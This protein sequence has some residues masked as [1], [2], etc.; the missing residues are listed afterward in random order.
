MTVHKFTRSPLWVTVVAALVAALVLV[1]VF[2]QGGR[3]AL[4]A[5]VPGTPDPP[6]VVG[7]TA[8]PNGKYPFIVAL[9]NTQFGSTPFQQ[10]FCGGTLI[11]Q[12]SVLTAAHCVF[13]ASAEPL[14]VTVGRTVLDNSN[15][16]KVRAVSSISI[17]PL[18]IPS[19]DDAFDA[20]V[21][22]L[23]NPV[24]GIAPIKLA[25]ANHDSLETPGR[26]VRVA[27]WGNTCQQPPPSGGCTSNFPNRMREA[28]VPI[29]SDTTAEQAYGSSVYFPT[30]MV[31]AGSENL[32][33]CQGDSGGPLFAK[34]AGAYRQIGITSFGIG[35]GAP[36]FPGVYSEVNNSSIRSFIVNAAN[37]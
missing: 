27:G 18:Y 9:L 35:C 2:L 15:Q 21:L 33:T 1:L 10:Q 26:L 19:L 16:G 23:S 31:A 4:A 12:D 20:A 13:G 22:K 25:N 24:S 37:S 32:D 34:S 3:S 11:D 8:V 17:H 36:G 29:V 7:G 6:Q 14:R 28:Q 30:L 5:E